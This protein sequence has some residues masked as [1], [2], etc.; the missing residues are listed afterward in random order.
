MW[1]YIYL[2]CWEKD[3]HASIS[4][5]MHFSIS[6]ACLCLLNSV[7]APFLSLILSPF[8][9]FRFFHILLWDGMVV[10]KVEKEKGMWIPYAHAWAF[11]HTCC[12]RAIRVHTAIHTFRALDLPQFWGISTNKTPYIIW[13]Y[14]WKCKLSRSSVWERQAACGA[15]NGR[16]PLGRWAPLTKVSSKC[17][18]G[19]LGKWKRVLIKHHI[20]GDNNLIRNMIQTP[21][22]FMVCGIAKRN[23][24]GGAGE[25]VCVGQ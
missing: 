2:F 19:W 6:I 20:A 17:L 18:G 21:I 14:D 9:P 8:F 10:K 23:E 4:T 5:F 22:S 3:M 12:R 7:V 13:I 1:I 24:Q 16:S 25:R 11:R 15:D